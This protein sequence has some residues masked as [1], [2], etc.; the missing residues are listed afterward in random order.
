M[1]KGLTTTQKAE[2]IKSEVKT[3]T[4]LVLELEDGN[5]NILENDTLATFT[6]SGVNYVAGMVKRGEIQTSMESMV[7]KCSITISNINQEISNLIYSGGTLTNLNVTI[8]E[9]IFNGFPADWQANTT[10]ALNSYVSPT[11]K[12]SY[13]YK[14]TT[15]GTTHATT[16]P[17]WTTTLGGTNSDNTAVWT[18]TTPIIDDPIELFSG[19]INNVKL[20]YTEFSFDVVR[21]I[22]DY[23]FV[24]PR[25]TYD[26]S[27]QVKKFKDIRCG[28]SGGETWCDKTMSRCVQLSNQTNFYGFPSITDANVI[29]A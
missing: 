15:G 10:Y 18:C 6:L 24:S 5:L 3:R 2:I 1:T 20:S 12:N 21:N 11:T 13:I 25:P 22:G 19:K 4:L 29:K 16:E 8:S 27:C 9:V 7:E 23:S 28:Y 17:T 26:C 14:C